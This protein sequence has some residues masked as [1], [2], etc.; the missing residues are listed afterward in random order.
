ML[1]DLKNQLDKRGAKTIRGL[2]RVFR[3]MDS[4]NGNKL[5]DAGEFFSGLQE[6]GIDITKDQCQ[7]DTIECRR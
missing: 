2:A 6:I 1:Q 3:N 5:V 4:F 7:V